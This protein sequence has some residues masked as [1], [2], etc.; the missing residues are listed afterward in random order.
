MTERIRKSKSNDGTIMSPQT[1]ARQPAGGDKNSSSPLNPE[2]SINGKNQVSSYQLDDDLKT[3]KEAAKKVQDFSKNLSDMEGDLSPI[4]TNHS[5]Q[6]KSTSHRNLLT[7]KQN[8]ASLNRSAIYSGKE[9]ESDR[10]GSKS[11]RTA[12]SASDGGKFDADSDSMSDDDLN[13]SAGVK[14]S[15]TKCCCS[16]FGLSVNPSS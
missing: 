5:F 12:S 8:S 7:S 1:E 2:T 9:Y 13:A 14:K 4:D 6:P 15:L 3:G 16:C 10:D 11:H